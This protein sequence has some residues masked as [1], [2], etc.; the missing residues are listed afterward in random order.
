MVV[1]MVDAQEAMAS[2]WIDMGR[3]LLIGLRN[4]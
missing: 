4:I 3:G 2:E 1:V